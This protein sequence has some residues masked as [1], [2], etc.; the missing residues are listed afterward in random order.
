MTPNHDGTVD[1]WAHVPVTGNTASYHS[2]TIEAFAIPHYIGLYSLCP[3]RLLWEEFGWRP[4][5]PA[6]KRAIAF[7][8]DIDSFDFGD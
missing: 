4:Q 7:L 2:I 6:A 8:P 3:E 1:L 5:A